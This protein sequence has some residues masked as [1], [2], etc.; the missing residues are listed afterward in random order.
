MRL[1]QGGRVSYTLEGVGSITY[2]LRC[3]AAVLMRRQPMYT[4]IDCFGALKVLLTAAFPSYCS[5]TAAVSAL[6]G[7]AMLQSQ[8]G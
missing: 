4:V 3:C 7:S 5:P 1:R 8:R 6:G 2:V